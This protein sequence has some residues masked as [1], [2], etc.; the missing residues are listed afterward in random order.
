MTGKPHGWILKHSLVL[1]YHPAFALPSG[2]LPCGLL[3]SAVQQGGRPAQPV[4]FPHG[5]FPSPP[6]LPGALLSLRISAHRLTAGYLLWP[7]CGCPAGWR[8]RRIYA[9]EPLA[10]VSFSVSFSQKEWGKGSRTDPAGAPLSWEVHRPADRPPQ[11]GENPPK[12]PF[13]FSSAVPVWQAFL[14]LSCQAASAVSSLA[15][16]LRQSGKP[17][18]GSS[19]SEGRS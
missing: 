1:P 16:A 7:A 5:A 17:P 8:Y 3:S 9:H 18:A 13:S 15:P 6:A 11:K 12:S 19:K 14:L 10:P 4:S 2:S